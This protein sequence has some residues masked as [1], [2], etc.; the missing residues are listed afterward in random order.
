MGCHSAHFLSSSCTP[1]TRPQPPEGRAPGAGTP[2]H[3][4]AL[5]LGCTWVHSLGLVAQGPPHRG[6]HVGNCCCRERPLGQAERRRALPQQSPLKAR[7]R[8]TRG[9]GRGGRGSGGEGLAASATAPFQSPR[10]APHPEPQPCGCPLPGPPP[11]GDGLVS[12]WPWH[13]PQAPAPASRARGAARGSQSP[14]GT[15]SGTPAASRPLAPPS[16]APPP[17]APPPRLGAPSPLWAPQHPERVLESERTAAREG[18]AWQGGALQQQ[19][20]QGWLPQSPA[21]QGLCWVPGCQCQSETRGW[22]WGWAQWLPMRG[23]HPAPLHE[24][25]ARGVPAA[26]RGCLPSASPS[27]ATRPPPPPSPMAAEA[28]PRGR[29]PSHHRW[30][31]DLS[32]SGAASPSCAC[33]RSSPCTCT[34]SCGHPC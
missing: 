22:G 27:T 6:F 14:G 26:A 11:W 18:Q 13:P 5:P 16:L 15:A 21:H 1:R 2:L 33:H 31:R 7:T 4:A 25:P 32:G 28:A 23:L 12:S 20:R 30:R 9:G 3:S 17:L 10:P 8:A 29:R 24:G 19:G 34:S